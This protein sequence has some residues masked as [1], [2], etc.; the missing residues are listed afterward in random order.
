MNA[1]APFDPTVLEQSST[2]IRSFYHYWC[3]IRGD[4]AMPRRADF[5]PM[6]IPG[7]LPGILLVDVEGVNEEG[8]GQFRYRVA[9]DLEITAR[10]FNP[11]GKRVEDGTFQGSKKRAISNYETV[12]RSAAPLYKPITYLN[13]HHL[14]IDEYVLFLPFS[15]DGETVSQILVFAE[16]LERPNQP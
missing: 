14:M 11:M 7:H 3:D 10:G 13:A 1:I 15:E 5:D 9:G 12:R 4:R 16:R 2:A 6:D 8:I